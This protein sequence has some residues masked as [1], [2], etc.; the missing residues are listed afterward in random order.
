MFRRSKSRR[1]RVADAARDVVD[2]GAASAAELERYVRQATADA[3]E[4]LRDSARSLRR[5]SDETYEDLADI[6]HDYP[7]ATIAIA[8]AC[9]AL[10]ALMLRR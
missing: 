4:V 6:V 10:M 2:K 8:C 7:V 5:R 9:G 1:E 3:E